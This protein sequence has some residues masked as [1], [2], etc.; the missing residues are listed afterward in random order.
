MRLRP[1]IK[2]DLRSLV[3]VFTAAVQIL[4]ADYYDAAQRD[5]WAPRQPDLDAWQARL[6]GLTVWVA[7]DGMALKGFIAYTGTG[8]ID[9]L[10]TS[11]AAPR[12]GIAQ[13]LYA[14]AEADLFARG[15]NILTADVSRVAEPFFSRQGFVIVEPQVVTR[16]GV[17]FKRYAMRKSLP[18][19]S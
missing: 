6:S 12:R 13:Q 17:A 15:V 3:D 7:H 10:F 2:D 8:H 14:R 16:G 4:A 5:A 11:P 9:L 1:Y 18:E 19:A